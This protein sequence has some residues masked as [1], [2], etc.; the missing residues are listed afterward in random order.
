MTI[1]HYLSCSKTTQPEELHRLVKDNVACLALKDNRGR[2]ALHAAVTRGNVALIAY[3]LKQGIPIQS[4]LRDPEGATLLHYAAYSRR[5]ETFDLVAHFYEDLFVEDHH[6]RSVLHYTAGANN[7]AAV[8]KVVEELG[9]ASLLHR[10]CSSG[11][12]PAQLAMRVGARSVLAYINTLT[13]KGTS[14]VSLCPAADAQPNGQEEG[15][16]CLGAFQRSALPDIGYRIDRR[17]I[18]VLLA[19]LLVLF[20]VRNFPVSWNDCPSWGS[21]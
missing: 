3:F 2:S 8:R 17:V 6:G 11:E 7:A 18:N 14:P 1:L 16:P 15:T 5:T 10:P 21:R 12:T 9:G 4:N 19:I 20:C 13:E